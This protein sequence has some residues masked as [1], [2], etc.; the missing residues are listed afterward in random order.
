MDYVYDSRYSINEF[1][2]PGG[3][4]IVLWRD[5][6]FYFIGNS[7][8][9]LVFRLINPSKIIYD[10]KLSIYWFTILFILYFS[11]VNEIHR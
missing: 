9:M 11:V 6:I 10:W 7:M 8:K 1:I 4:S 2:I 5:S 3:K